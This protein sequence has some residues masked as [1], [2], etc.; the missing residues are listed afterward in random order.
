MENSR[1]LRVLMIED[2]EDDSRLVLLEL[3]KGGWEI[4]HTRVDTATALSDAYD[5]GPWDLIFS[6][7]TR[8]K[9]SGLAALSLLKSKKCEIP[10]FLVS[11]TAGEENAVKAMKAG[12]H[13]YI[14]KDN[15]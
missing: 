4:E 1:K 5:Q 6:D 2:S 14:M 3:K 10:F 7:Y 12:A 8:P 15:L 13:D 9:F 11:G